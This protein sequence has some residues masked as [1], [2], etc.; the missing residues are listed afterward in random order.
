MLAIA[1]QPTVRNSTALRDRPEVQR[2]IADSTA[3]IDSARAYI[4]EVVTA[5][6]DAVCRDQ[7][8]TRF[9]AASRLAFAHAAQQATFVV[10]ELIRVVGTPAA[11]LSSPLRR[12]ARDLMVAQHFPSFDISTYEVAGRVFLGVEHDD[13][14]W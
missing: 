11:H 3:R 4:A 8:P 9:V 14:G 7:D 1:G 6:Y 5:A 10:G 2:C 12:R 13:P